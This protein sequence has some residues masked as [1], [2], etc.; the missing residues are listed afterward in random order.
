MSSPLVKAFGAGSSDLAEYVEST[1]KPEDEILLE[2]R[3]R[4]EREGLPPIHVGPMDGRHLEV[5]ARLS[6]AKKAVEIGTLAGYSGVCLLRG[7]S[8]EAKLW[9]IDADSKHTRVAQESFKRSGFE[10]QVHALSGYASDRLPDVETNGP[11]DLVFIDADKAGYPHYLEWAQKNLR[12]GGVVI[13]D[14][15]LG[16]GKIHLGEKAPAEYLESVLA[17]RKFNS[18]VANGKGW[19]ATLL[20]TAE[21]LTVAVKI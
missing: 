2:I 13:G 6:G 17:L 7:M 3:S 8:K 1:F 14:N 11:F 4:A 12:V 19:R 16:F 9:T 20:P 18:A 15:T 21:G 10:A 5:L